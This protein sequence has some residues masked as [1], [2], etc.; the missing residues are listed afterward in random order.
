MRRSDIH[1]LNSE[2]CT[3]CED[4]IR[5][6]SS[7]S[8]AEVRTS[9]IGSKHACGFDSHNQLA[10]VRHFVRKYTLLLR[11]N[12]LHPLCPI[13]SALDRSTRLGILR[14]QQRSI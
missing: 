10:P 12:P 13:R 8:P 6:N 14:P 4:S 5:L 7:E 9:L 2:K 3:T 11:P 1:A